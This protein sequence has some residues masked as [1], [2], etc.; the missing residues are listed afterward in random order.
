M[1]CYYF[2]YFFSI[3]TK[4]S[5]ICG[6]SC[7]IAISVFVLR[8]FGSQFTFNTVKLFQMRSAM[9]AYQGY[10]PVSNSERDIT[11]DSVEIEVKI[12]ELFEQ[13]SCIR[14]T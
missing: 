11:Y 5:T 3:I 9:C 8:I 13:T 10:L 6:N 7:V 2:F 14:K 1:I 4:K 12:I